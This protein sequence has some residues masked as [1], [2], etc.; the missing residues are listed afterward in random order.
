[1]DFDKRQNLFVEA[2]QKKVGADGNWKLT[3]LFGVSNR[4]I[5]I[6]GALQIGAGNFDSWSTVPNGVILASVIRFP[7]ADEIFFAVVIEHDCE[8]FLQRLLKMKRLG[9]ILKE[10]PEKYT[11]RQSSSKKLPRQESMLEKSVPKEE[12]LDD[13]TQMAGEAGE[14]EYGTLPSDDS[15][16]DAIGDIKYRDRNN[17]VAIYLAEDGKIYMRNSGFWDRFPDDRTGLDPAVEVDKLFFSVYPPAPSAKRNLLVRDFIGYFVSLVGRDKVEELQPWPDEL[18][19][20]PLMRRMPN[21]IS[22]S[23][24]ASSVQKLGGYF[25]GGLLERYHVALN[26]LEHKHFVILTGLSGTGKTSL[27]RFY[28]FATHG[29]ENDRAEDP[30]FFMCSVRP[31]WTDPTGLI[32]YHDIIS[33]K[34]VVTPFL[35]AILIATAYKDTP[36]F[37]CIDEMNI[38]RAEFYFAD[39]LSAM[40]S[41]MPLHL[42]SNSVPLD[43]SSGEQVPSEIRLPSNLFI[44][45]TINIDESTQPLSDKI[46]DRANI[47]DMSV[48]DIT[49]FLEN[50]ASRY[51]ELKP[52]IDDCSSILIQLDN[53]L[54]PHKLG[55][56]YRMIEEFIR[57]YAFVKATGV[58]QPEI[59]IDSQI[60]Q[61]VLVKLKGGENQRGLLEKLT[62]MLQPYSQS[63]NIVEDLKQQLDEFGSFQYL[64]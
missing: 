50:L 40:E 55:F 33:G 44:S 28:A 27:V 24:I 17:T 52:A 29:I 14:Y 53:L 20:S 11:G 26:H 54:L 49:G 46:L 5:L 35:Q 23:D 31:D 34:Y 25:A 18:S 13:T 58:M 59:A 2:V 12:S 61:K 39:A 60:A 37:V 57:Y 6:E 19:I 10:Q 45:G 41:R 8:K 42:H 1:M 63:R 36:V 16:T 7:P 30:F 43:G 22:L 62:R 21:T 38:A 56:G 15:S 51:T 3:R 4:A 9:L 32:G 47:I 48:V 64:R